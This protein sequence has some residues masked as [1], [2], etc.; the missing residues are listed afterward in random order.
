MIYLVAAIA[1][2]AGILFG[3]DEGVVAGALLHL[4][5]EFQITPAAE[6]LMTSAVP[7]GA[8]L[9]A[10]VAGYAAERFGRRASLLVAA[11]LFVAGAIG[12]GTFAALWVLTASR[13]VLGFAV[14]VAALVAPLYISEC[15]PASLRGRL[16]SVYQLSVTVG[17]LFAYLVNYGFGDD[18]RG[19]FLVGAAPGVLLLI[20]MLPLSDTPRWLSE[21]RGADAA[22]A[23]LARLYG[24]APHAPEVD[25]ELATI[26][27]SHSHINERA[28]WRDLLSRQTRPA[29]VVGVGLFL[30]QQFSGINAVIYYAPRVFEESGFATH[31]T[32]ILATVGIGV[33]NVA[34]TVVGMALIDR[35]GRRPLLYIGFAGAAASLALIALSAWLDAHGMA[36][37]TVAGLVIYIGAFAASL[38][39]LPYVLM[40]EVFPRHVRALGMSAAT[41]ANWG[42][43][44]VVVFSFPILVSEFGLGGVF[45]FYALICVG[46]LFFT[47][48]YVPETN[49]VP[50]EAIEAHLETGAPFRELHAPAPTFDA[51]AIELSRTLPRDQAEALVNGLI[52]FSPYRSDLQPMARRVA[53]LA[54]ENHQVRIALHAIWVR[55]DYQKTRRVRRG[56]LGAQ[57]KLISMFLEHVRYASPAFLA[58]VGEGG[59]VTGDRS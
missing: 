12:S 44:F 47:H 42:L 19:M 32:Q 17:I 31:S 54:Y 39:P 36:F 25:R 58:S 22:R 40:S 20:G 35:I 48:R 33:V 15:A 24:L 16:V 9:G 1:G 52:G 53:S 5:R 6:G 59:S 8:L 7:L 37:I 51:A 27:A 30:L 55:S 34:M 21:R 28:A 26:E 46:G 41:L 49:G 14:G 11:L 57:A 18:W 3:F 45:A 23:A 2:L 38:G 10:I 56:D 29:L 50:L 4:R 43:N 13:L